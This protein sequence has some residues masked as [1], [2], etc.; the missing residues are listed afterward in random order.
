MHGDETEIFLMH[1]THF[2]LLPLNVEGISMQPLDRAPTITPFTPTQSLINVT[3]IHAQ[4]CPV[5]EQKCELDT[6]SSTLGI[7][8]SVTR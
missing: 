1:Q 5:S 2:T 3:C 6:D 8:N 4:L 7:D